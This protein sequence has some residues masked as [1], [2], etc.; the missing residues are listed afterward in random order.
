MNF[1]SLI[2][3]ILAVGLMTTKAWALGLGPIEVTS[4]LNEMF[5]A[6]IELLES[7]L[8]SGDDIR[9]SL[10]DPEKFRAAGVPRPHL[11]TSL[12]FEVRARP[13]GNLYIAV[14]SREPIREPALEFLLQVAWANGTLL[15]KYSILLDRRITAGAPLSA[16]TG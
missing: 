5:Y 9:I 3:V 8:V 4:A 11:L 13:S 1:K 16:L 10:A 15:Q 12:E 7:E 6:R 14:S 2:G